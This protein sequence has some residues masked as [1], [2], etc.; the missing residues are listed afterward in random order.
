[1][2][3]QPAKIIVPILLNFDF[4][5][6]IGHIVLDKKY[7]KFFPKAE[8]DVGYIAGIGEDQG[9]LVAVGLCRVPVPC[10]RLSRK[11]PKCK[12][13]TMQRPV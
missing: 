5:E 13:V 6:K 7:E 1:M 4:E 8:F 9:K 2:A 11:C 10:K 12:T 3:K